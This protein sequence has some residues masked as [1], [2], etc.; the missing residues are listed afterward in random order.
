[1]LSQVASHAKTLAAPEKEQE[2]KESDQDCGEKWQ[3]S[4]AKYD[5]DTCSWKTH[6]CSLFG[7]LEPYSEAWP[8]WGMMRNGACW[9][10]NIARDIQKGS[11][12]GYLPAPQASD[13]KIIKEFKALSAFKNDKNGH[14]RHLP[15]LALMNSAPLSTLILVTEETMDWPKQWTDLKPLGMDKFHKWLHSHGAYSQT[16]K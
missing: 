11:G 12:C 6:Q 16:S 5:L 14:Q 9:V 7:G 3:G 4:F 10:V 2:S 15:H 8:R 1:M 13:A